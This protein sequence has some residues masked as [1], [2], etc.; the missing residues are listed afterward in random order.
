MTKPRRCMTHKDQAGVRSTKARQVCMA[1]CGISGQKQRLSHC[2]DQLGSHFFKRRVKCST[3]VHSR[4]L[5]ISMVRPPPMMCNLSP[6][7]VSMLRPFLCSSKA[8][9]S[10]QA[11]RSPASLKAAIPTPSPLLLTHWPCRNSFRPS[12]LVTARRVR[13]C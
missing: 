9:R 11:C 13:N 6:I 7:Q 3:K 2:S 5:R 12:I 4:K 8:N 1:M 10:S